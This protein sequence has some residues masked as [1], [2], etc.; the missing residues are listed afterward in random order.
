MYLAICHYPKDKSVKP[1]VHIIALRID[2]SGWLPHTL[3]DDIYGSQQGFMTNYT[4]NESLI[5][6]FRICDSPREIQAYR[7]GH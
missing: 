2:N 7:G 6:E 4:P 1:N 5:F 3:N